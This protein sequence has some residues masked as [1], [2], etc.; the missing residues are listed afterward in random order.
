MASGSPSPFHPRLI[1]AALG[2]WVLAA[3]VSAGQG[4]AFGVFSGR[5]QPWWPTLAYSLAIFSIWALISPFLLAALSHALRIEKVSLRIAALVLGAP[6]AMLLHVAV[7]AVAFHPI[8]G[9]GRSAVDMIAPVLAS[10]IDTAAL[11]YGLLIAGARLDIRRTAGRSTQPAAEGLWIRNGAAASFVGYGEIDWIAAAGD[12]A[13][14]HAGARSRLTDQSLTA[15]ADVLP[16]AEFAR[17]HRSAIVRLDRV[18]RI[19]G[20]GRGDA[21]VEL[22]DGRRLRLSRRF[23]SGLAG[24]LPV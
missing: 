15:L 19:Q 22:R 11:A 23:R 5:T 14:I 8:Y 13:E 3:F 18:R 20:V 9:Q 16:A 1:A 2:A 24:R 6:L 12:Y 7:F 4:Y 21:E 17:I 10:N